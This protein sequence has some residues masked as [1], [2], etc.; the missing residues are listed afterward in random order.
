MERIRRM[1][2]DSSWASVSESY[3]MFVLKQPTLPKTCHLQFFV[4]FSHVK[5]PGLPE[6]LHLTTSRKS[7]K[8]LT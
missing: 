1:Q 8:D 4:I 3:R 7:Q 2:A 5:H 6:Q